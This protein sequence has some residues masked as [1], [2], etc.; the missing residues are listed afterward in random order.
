MIL[1]SSR[2]TNIWAVMV[3]EAR[4]PP[5][6]VACQVVVVSEVVVVAFALI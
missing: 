6:K 1:S 2:P 4:K 3:T 5:L